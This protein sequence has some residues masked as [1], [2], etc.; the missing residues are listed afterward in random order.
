MT[1]RNVTQ[2]TEFI[3]VG[4]AHQPVPGIVGLFLVFLSLYLLAL[5]GNVGMMGLIQLDPRLHTPM[6]FFLSHLSLLDTCYASVIVPQI[7]ATLMS[8]DGLAVS[9]WGCAA[10]FF[11]FTVCAGTECYLLAVMAYDRYMAV[12][13]PLLY[14][15]A[16]TRGTCVA[17]VAGAYAG[18]LVGATLRT[19]LTFTLSFCDANRIDFF[20][21][22]LPPLLKLTCSDP[23]IREKVIIF[24]GNFVILAN[25]LVI[26]VSYLFIARAILHRRTAGG[27]AKTFSTCASHLT[28]VGLFFGTLAL[29]YLRGSSGKSLEGDK[30]VSVLYSVVIPALNPLIYSLRNGQ[31]K[32]ALHRALLRLRLALGLQ[33]REGGFS[34]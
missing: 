27:R 32:A 34:S 20:F 5:L 15:S 23:S 25:G 14:V 9:Y 10:Q 22:D 29:T 12:G 4:F 16:M 2:V 1:E 26:L 24:L 7:L 28:A 8:D 6:Y 17:L 30:V 13:N 19:A 33:T 11:L 31:V 3:L 21:C 18:G